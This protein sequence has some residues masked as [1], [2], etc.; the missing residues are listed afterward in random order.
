[1]D[2]A[3]ASGYG[4]VMKFQGIKAL[5][6]EKVVQSQM[7]PR[8]SGYTLGRHLALLSALTLWLGF[9][10]PIQA[11][12]QPKAQPEFRCHACR[13]QD[14]SWC[15]MVTQSCALPAPP[16]RRHYRTSPQIQR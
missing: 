7:R 8:L 9:Q 11:G 16:G 14:L 4:K 13:L 3:D 2:I 6:N 1:M 5:N 15:G 12:I 10:E